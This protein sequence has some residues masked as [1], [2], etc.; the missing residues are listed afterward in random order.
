MLCSISRLMQIYLV[1]LGNGNGN[2]NV[3]S[4]R[5]LG[6]ASG[7][8]ASC[9]HVTYRVR[10]RRSTDLAAHAERT[11]RPS[12]GPHCL[13]PFVGQRRQRQRGPIRCSSNHPL[14]QRVPQRAARGSAGGGKHSAPAIRPTN[15]QAAATEQQQQQQKWKQARACQRSVLPLSVSL[16]CLPHFVA[17]Q[18]LHPQ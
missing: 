8:G 12:S 14:W 7:S 10:E 3:R 15:E 2:G 17:R 4:Y 18:I 11:F 16:S 1:D 6:S 5:A 13:N 9:E